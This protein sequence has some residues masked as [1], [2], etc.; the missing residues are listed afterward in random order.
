MI[1]TEKKLKR[2]NKNIIVT[3]SNLKDIITA[4]IPREAFEFYLNQYPLSN[5]PFDIKRL[6]NFICCIFTFSKKAINTQQLKKYLLE[7]LKWPGY[8][9]DWCI[10]R[11]E[12]GLDI[13]K[14]Y[15]KSKM[16]KYIN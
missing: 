11:I 5:H 4:K 16:I 7:K 12:T 3:E 2:N 14:E 1:V 13:L 8:N 6:D 10:R 9:V 15:K